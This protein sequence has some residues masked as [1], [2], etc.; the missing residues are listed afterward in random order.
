MMMR[1]VAR[2]PAASIQVFLF[3]VSMLGLVYYGSQAR[4]EDPWPWKGTPS[5]DTVTLLLL[6]D[7]N[8]QKRDDPADALVHVRATLNQADLVYANLEGLL[9]ESKGADKD[10]PNKSGWTHLGPEA[11]QALVAGNISVVGV[12]N[13]VAYGR[14]NISASLS[15]L[16]AHGIAHTG[17]GANIAEAHEPA[18]VEVKGVKFG[19]LQYTSKWYD[20]SRQIATADSAGVARLKSPDGATVDAAD[21][22]RLLADIRRTRPMVDILVVS[23]H[24]LDGQGRDGAARNG[25]AP[26]AAADRL[27]DLTS[28][29]PVNENLARFEPYQARL[30]REAIDAGAD[31]VFG[32]GCHMVQAVETYAS[33]PIMYCLGNFASDW[34]RVRDYRDGLVARVVVRDRKLSRVSV[35]PVTRDADTNNVRL[36]PPDSKDG[37]R[38]SSRL[39]A[40]SPSTAL[41]LEGRELV[42]LQEQ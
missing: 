1:P 16:D 41:T 19:F 4:A 33:R 35:V 17:A 5:E 29:L 7:F 36:L 34:I 39:R 22:E 24:T 28:R 32:H 2:T 23:A 18:I 38:L 21:M 13:N 26:S 12:A 37:A 27:A 15:V 20:E 9:V 40:L 14:A 42:L 8:V 30:A 10:L 3:G 31:V 11:V 6:G 25:A